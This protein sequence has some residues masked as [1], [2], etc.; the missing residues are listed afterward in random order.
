[1]LE[2]ERARLG[3]SPRYRDS[4]SLAVLVVRDMPRVWN[5]REDRKES[6]DGSEQVFERRVIVSGVSGA[7]KELGLLIACWA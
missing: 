6:R 2:L 3:K 1:M 4:L 7:R 5:H